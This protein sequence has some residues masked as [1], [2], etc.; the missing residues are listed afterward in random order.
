M[1]YIKGVGFELQGSAFNVY[2]PDFR[3]QGWGFKGLV[4]VIKKKKKHYPQG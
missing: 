2:R 1:D 3:D 4:R